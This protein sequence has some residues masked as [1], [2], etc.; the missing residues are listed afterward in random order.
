MHDDPVLSDSAQSA[1][2][3]LSAARGLYSAPSRTHA[4]NVCRGMKFDEYSL[5]GLDRTPA[6]SLRSCQGRPS[7]APMNT[8]RFRS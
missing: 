4:A 6:I 7:Y 3:A 2:A 8:R 1:T 5:L